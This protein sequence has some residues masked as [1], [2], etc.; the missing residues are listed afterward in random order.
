MRGGHREAREAVVDPTRSLTITAIAAPKEGEVVVGFP[1]G[2]AR[3]PQA[4]PKPQGQRE[5]RDGPRPS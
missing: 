5:Q 2:T 4:R 3:L 1:S